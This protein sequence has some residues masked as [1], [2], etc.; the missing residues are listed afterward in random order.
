MI[1]AAEH[2]MMLLKEKWKILQNI[3]DK[4]RTGDSAVKKKRSIARLGKS[5]TKSDL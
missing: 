3:E 5:R 4:R 1:S 2:N